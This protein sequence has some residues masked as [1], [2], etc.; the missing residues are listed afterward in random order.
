VRRG[1]VAKQVRCL[2]TTSFRTHVHVI[3]LYSFQSFFSLAHWYRGLAQGTYN[4]GGATTESR[5]PRQ[6]ALPSLVAVYA[7]YVLK[8]H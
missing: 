4:N 5:I 1:T 6:E 8:S 7:S 3:H 2:A